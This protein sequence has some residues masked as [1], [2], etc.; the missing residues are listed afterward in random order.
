MASSFDNLHFYESPRSCWREAEF[1]FLDWPTKTKEVIDLYLRLSADMP[2]AD[3]LSKHEEHVLV[4]F[5]VVFILGFLEAC[6]REIDRRSLIDKVLER[7][8][9]F[10]TSKHREI[11]SLSPGCSE[12][13]LPLYLRSKTR[14]IFFPTGFES[15]AGIS[16]SNA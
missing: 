2:E 14:A 8:E 12:R 9:A 16:A 5:A 11:E 4:S 13:L 3:T 1:S 15:H 6:Q 7:V 10:E